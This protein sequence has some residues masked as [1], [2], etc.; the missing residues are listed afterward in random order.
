MN[1]LDVSWIHRNASYS[2]RDHIQT[3][4]GWVLFQTAGTKRTLSHVGSPTRFRSQ[5]SIRDLNLTIMFP[6]HPLNFLELISL[7]RSYYEGYND[8]RRRHQIEV[9]PE[10]SR[11]YNHVSFNH[12]PSFKKRIVSRSTVSLNEFSEQNFA[13]KCLHQSKNRGF[14]PSFRLRNISWFLLLLTFSP[15]N[16][17]AWHTWLARTWLEDL[18]HRNLC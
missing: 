12:S 11:G 14:R 2:M 9:S 8:L 4:N 13:R 6:N 3:L 16:T 17:C 10:V 5:F 7:R 15:I 1:R 18:G